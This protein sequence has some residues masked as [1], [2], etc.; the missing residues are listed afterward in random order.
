MKLAEETR[1]VLAREPRC[2]HIRVC[3]S[4]ERH[5]YFPFYFSSSITPSVPFLFIFHFFFF[6]TIDGDPTN[7]EEFQRVRELATHKLATFETNCAVQTHHTTTPS[8]THHLLS[9]LLPHHSPTV[10]VVLLHNHSTPH[11]GVIH[12]N[13]IVNL[14]RCPPLVHNR[15]AQPP[16]HRTTHGLVEVVAV[17]LLQ[18][19]LS[20]C[21]PPPCTLHQLEVS[22]S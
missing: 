7:T 1:E 14:G 2:L 10:L 18:G 4:T 16:K 21:S 19:Q 15:N 3:S 8:R 5:F 12:Y 13:L 22:H 9:L 17:L 20:K 11:L 6:T